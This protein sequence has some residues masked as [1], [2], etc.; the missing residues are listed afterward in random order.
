[1][2]EQCAGAQF[3]G[4]NSRDGSTLTGTTWSTSKAFGSSAGASYAMGWRQSQQSALVRAQW[5]RIG[6]V[7]RAQAPPVLRPALG[8]G[9]GGH[10]TGQSLGRVDGASR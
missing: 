7:S 9:I 8:V 5:A 10:H 6:A 4:S 2:H 3:V 1:L